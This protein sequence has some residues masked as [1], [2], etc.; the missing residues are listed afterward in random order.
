MTESE[1]Y[2]KWFW[3]ALS[4]R[5]RWDFYYFNNVSFNCLHEFLMQPSDFHQMTIN[6]I[7]MQMRNPYSPITGKWMRR[8]RRLATHILVPE[9]VRDIRDTRFLNQVYQTRKR[10]DNA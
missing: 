10:H 1:K 9:M 2:E 6:R 7:H 4:Y 5:F 8:T 3:M